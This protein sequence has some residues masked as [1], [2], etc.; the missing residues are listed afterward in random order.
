MT[1]PWSARVLFRVEAAA[2]ALNRWCKRPAIAPFYSTSEDF[3]V[4][5]AEAARV[6]FKR[7]DANIL[8]TLSFVLFLYTSWGLYTGVISDFSRAPMIGQQRKLTEACAKAHGY[9]I[10]RESI[11]PW[12]NVSPYQPEAPKATEPAAQGDLSLPR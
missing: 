5:S 7:N 12:I 11:N 2:A 10:D 6:W 9:T 4:A 8:N 1:T 3:C